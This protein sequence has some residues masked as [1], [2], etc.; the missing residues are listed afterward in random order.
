MRLPQSAR[1]ASD[2]V[3]SSTQAIPGTN[4]VT[5][6]VTVEGRIPIGNDGELDPSGAS[7][8]FSFNLEK[9][10]VKVT[11]G[12]RMGLNEGFKMDAPCPTARGDLH[13]TST[14][15]VDLDT[16]VS[17]G[18]G[19]DYNTTLTLIHGGGSSKTVVN[20]GATLGK[21]TYSDGVSITT[22]KEVSI[23]HGLYVTG[24]RITTVAH[25]T[26]TI[27]GATGNVTLTDISVRVVG[28][29]AKGLGAGS[30][31]AD[32]AKANADANLADTFR[33]LAIDDGN[34]IWNRY[35]GAEDK[36][37]EPNHCAKLT[38][39]PA[40]DDH[41]PGGATTKVAGRIGPKDGGTSDSV[42]G[43]PTVSRGH[44][45]GIP[46]RTSAA[47]PVQV[48]VTGDAPDA[49]RVTAGFDERARSRAG[50]AESHWLGSDS[51]WLVTVTGPVSAEQTCCWVVSG[52]ATAKIP[53][54]QQTVGGVTGFHG[55]APWVDTGLTSGSNGNPTQCGYTLNDVAGTASATI[56]PSADG[57]TLSIKLTLTDQVTATMTCP[58][59]I[60]PATI[61]GVFAASYYLQSGGQ[62]PVVT[63]PE[64][65]SGSAQITWKVALF[66]PAG[67]S[68]RLTVTVSRL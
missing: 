65:G 57:K 51:G 7:L 47:Q 4:G 23:L 35:W 54:T 19:V 60:P 34:S 11:Q 59:P 16:S 36:F 49:N 37:Q 44:V 53:V 55:T 24:Y 20:P 8:G 25:W 17:P 30:F 43:P 42:W 56:T 32:I 58:S 31:A 9:N 67:S 38:F 45:R 29:G 52:T 68:G 27:D 26:G 5:G 1:T 62:A 64:N 61:G 28:D 66:S 48:T 14:I 39:D 10:G 33:Q 12:I 50:V 63:L 15:N 21:I 18:G 2:L 13:G 3:Q 6:T 22:A 46:A 41:L 40:S